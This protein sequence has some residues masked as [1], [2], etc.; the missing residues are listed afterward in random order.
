M[1]LDNFRCN[2]FCIVDGFFVVLIC[3]WD[4]C[5]EREVVKEEKFVCGN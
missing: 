2:S 5:L 3:V 1:A 4:D